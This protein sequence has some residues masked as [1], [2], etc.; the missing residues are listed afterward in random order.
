MD[1]MQ[2]WFC[3]AQGIQ[4]GSS[5]SF[6]RGRQALDTVGSSGNATT[7]IRGADFAPCM[8]IAS[9][10]DTRIAQGDIE[11]PSVFRAVNIAPSTA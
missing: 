7:E 11:A 8:P 10:Q 6:Q 9:L 2:Q 4:S 5:A 3:R 1:G